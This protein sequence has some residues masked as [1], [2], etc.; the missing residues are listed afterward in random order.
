MGVHWKS[1]QTQRN[2]LGKSTLAHKSGNLSPVLQAIS[3]ELI[4]PSGE[5]IVNGGF[6]TG[7][8]TGWVCNDGVVTTD[9]PHSGTYCAQVYPSGPRQLNQTLSSPILV[10][11]IS[12]FNFWRR[13]SQSAYVRVVYSD[14]TNTGWITLPDVTPWTDFD[15]MPYLTS[16]KYVS[17]INFLNGYVGSLY[18]DDVSLIGT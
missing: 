15:L 11:C 1:K 9:N 2:L 14:G 10:G 16:G 6:E 5:Q 8:F 3:P 18:I 13:N 17:E 12:S 7:D 4:C